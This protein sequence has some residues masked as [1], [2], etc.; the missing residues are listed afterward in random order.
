MY[1][2]NFRADTTSNRDDLPQLGCRPF[3]RISLPLSTPPLT[4]M[5]SAS[6]RNRWVIGSSS[7]RLNHRRDYQSLEVVNVEF[8]Q[9]E[10][11][12]YSY[13]IAKDSN[14]DIYATFGNA[15]LKHTVSTS[16]TEVWAGSVLEDGPGVG[17]RSRSRF[18]SPLGLFWHK[19]WLYVV[20]AH[21]IQRIKGDLVEGYAGSSSAGSA[22]GP[23]GDARF[24]NPTHMTALHD[25]FYLTDSFN[26][27]IRK[28]TSDGQVTRLQ[29][30]A[31]DMDPSVELS[32]PIFRYPRG[33]CVGPNEKLLVVESSKASVREI[34][35]EDN[36]LR[37]FAYDRKTPYTFALH[38]LQSETRELIICDTSGDCLWITDPDGQEKRLV[39]TE[40]G[41]M[42]P[43]FAANRPTAACISDSGDLFWTSERG[44]FGVI[45]SMFP[46]KR[47]NKF[48]FSA[49][50]HPS[51]R[52][53]SADQSNSSSTIASST[54][55]L[56]DLVLHHHASGQ[57][58]STNSQLAKLLEIEAPK[59]LETCDVPFESCQSFL[60][61]LYGSSPT[62]SSEIPYLRLAHWVIL[63]EVVQ[64]SINIRQLLVSAL[65]TRI[66]PLDVKQISDVFIDATKKPLE[67]HDLRSV[68]AAELTKRKSDDPDDLIGILML[69]LSLDVA[70]PT[71]ILA[72]NATPYTTPSH[73]LQERLGILTSTIR[74]STT[75]SDSCGSDPEFPTNFTFELEFTDGM[76]FIGVHDWVLG[77]RWSFF[78]RMIG[79]G[80][81][82]AKRRKARLPA[83]FPPS[84]ALLL[85]RYIYCGVVD[86]ETL[87][88]AD[89]EYLLLNGPAYGITDFNDSP[90]SGFEDLV[91]YCKAKTMK[92]VAEEAPASKLAK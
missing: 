30:T 55:S 65:A 2:P 63:A 51:S 84:L 27:T 40:G 66:A 8:P 26:H 7:S 33:I 85:I 67:T 19:H 35:L 29:L 89:S 60:D 57:T 82:E 43:K 11:P 24:N 77:P 31:Y 48:D 3:W 22:D 32:A 5:A 17:T 88:E 72:T 52:E 39:A 71:A 23:R 18:R 21:G 86:H 20:Q 25:T 28:I 49:A 9:N 74:M 76:H 46:P 37:P 69:G 87:S 92:S 81:E 78:E 73:W 54:A 6:D 75:E 70:A 59:A 80:L 16:T 45:R 1:F 83:D 4:I 42:N 68:F 14:G 50:L 15:I 62:I 79:S 61:F 64:A 47:L 56:N 10:D 90:S 91:R 38:L 13:G 44:S 36:S 53:P 58:I 41:L 34:D 12:K